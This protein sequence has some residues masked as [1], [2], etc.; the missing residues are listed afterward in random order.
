VLCLFIPYLNGSDF[1][2]TIEVDCA[3]DVG[4]S[5][6][7]HQHALCVTL[8]HPGGHLD[9]TAYIGLHPKYSQHTH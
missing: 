5:A 8:C 3:W 1:L 4:C 7:L 2:A 9:T 6:W